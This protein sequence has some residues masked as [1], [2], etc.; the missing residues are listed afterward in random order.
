MRNEPLAVATGCL[1]QPAD[2]LEEVMSEQDLIN[3][4]AYV[5]MAKAK[6]DLD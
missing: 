6:L 3:A 2:S 1:T 5:C 4:I